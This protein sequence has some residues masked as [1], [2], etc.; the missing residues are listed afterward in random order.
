MFREGRK[1]GDDGDGED[2][3][4]KEGTIKQ[5]SGKMAK[6]RRQQASKREFAAPARV[7]DGG[8]ENERGKE[9]EV[10]FPCGAQ[11]QSTQIGEA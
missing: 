7:E 11:P 6:I 1:L 3:G 2:D 8:Q 5:S 9:Q 4:R 10:Q